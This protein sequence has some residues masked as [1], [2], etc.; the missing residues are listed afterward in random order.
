VWLKGLRDS[1]IPVWGIC[2]SDKAV[3]GKVTSAADVQPATIDL[4]H[5]FGWSGLPCQLCIAWIF[6]ALFLVCMSSND[7]VMVPAIQLALLYSQDMR[8]KYV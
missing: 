2:K 4:Q 7:D 1:V 8:L 6:S 3:F 5:L